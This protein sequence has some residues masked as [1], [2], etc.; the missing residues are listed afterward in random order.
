MKKVLPERMFA[1][2]EQ[3]R[4]PV[5]RNDPRIFSL[6][7]A[8]P[9][10]ASLVALALAA[11]SAVAQQSQNIAGTYRGQMTGCFSQERSIDCR[12]GFTELI[13]LADG[14]DA[15]RIEWER[16]N[17]TSDASAAKLQEDYALALTR[18]NRAVADF[19]RNMSSPPVQ[20]K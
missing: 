2:V 7:A 14:V 11:S 8:A 16:A 4:L 18:L 5:V 10:A 9:Y 3:S 12:K 15:R 19:N 17:A 13:Q 1:D 20:S 6:S